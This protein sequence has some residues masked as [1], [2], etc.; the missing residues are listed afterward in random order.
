MWSES[1]R[2]MSGKVKQS[3]NGAAAVFIL[4]TSPASLFTFDASVLS[5]YSGKSSQRSSGSSKQEGIK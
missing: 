4:L 5:D 3:I 2:D 1:E